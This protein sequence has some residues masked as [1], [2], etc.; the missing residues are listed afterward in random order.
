MRQKQIWL[1]SLCFA[2]TLFLYPFPSTGFLYRN[3]GVLKGKVSGVK[4]ASVVLFLD[5]SFYYRFRISPSDLESAV[6]ALGL[7]ESSHIEFDMNTL[8]RH[9]PWFW[10]RWWWRPVAGPLTCLYKGYIEGNRF[11][12]LY[13][14]ENHVAHL[15]IQNT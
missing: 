3:A 12:F 5:P 4:G 13:N 11:Y 7:S 1:I 15:Y 6:S 9:G 2:V 14:Y 10:N 8:K